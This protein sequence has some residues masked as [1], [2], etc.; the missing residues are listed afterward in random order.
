MGHVE[1][2]AS[3]EKGVVM[4]AAGSEANR[5]FVGLLEPSV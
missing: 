5:G 4:M 2:M 1:L 3:V